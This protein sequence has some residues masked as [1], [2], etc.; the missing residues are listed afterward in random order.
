M[1]LSHLLCQ[2]RDQH[3]QGE[4]TEVPTAGELLGRTHEELV[5][6]LIQLRRRHA[7]THRAI[8]QC[9]LQITSIEV[10]IFVFVLFLFSIGLLV[11]CGISIQSIVY[12]LQISLKVKFPQYIMYCLNSYM[13]SSGTSVSSKNRD[14]KTY[15]KITYTNK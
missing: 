9:C 11:S 7:A 5:L 12:M 3:G 13:S 14:N 1:L 6:L 8:E 15:L 10:L 2:P 4:L